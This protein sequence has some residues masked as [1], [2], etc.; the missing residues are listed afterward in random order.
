MALVSTSL[1]VL[2]CRSGDWRVT[3]IHG[4][5]HPG[6][7]SFGSAGCSGYMDRDSLFIGRLLDRTLTVLQKKKNLTTVPNMCGDRCGNRRNPVRHE[8]CLRILFDEETM[9]AP[10]IPADLCNVFDFEAVARECLPEDTW[11]YLAEGSDDG[12]TLKANRSAFASIQIRARRLVDVS[13]IDTT[14][15]LPGESLDSPILIAP[16][17]LQR[18]FHADAEIATVRATVAAG[19]RF[20][21]S[22]VSSCSIAKIA[23]AA[24]L[25]PWF[26]IYAM[27]DHGVTREIVRRA[28]AAGC[29]VMI[30]TVDVPVLGNRE[31][32]LSDLERRLQEG[33]V[34]LGN[35]EGLPRPHQIGDPSLTWSFIAEL[36]EM[37]GAK[38]FVKGIVTRGDAKLC[39][40]H[41]VDGVIVSNHG[42]RQEDSLRGSIE[43]L[44]EVVDVIAGR[45]P[46]LLDSGIRRGTDIF[47]GLALGAAAVCVGRPII[48]GLASFG[49]A[50]VEAVLQRLQQELVRVMQLAG[51]PTIARIDRTAVMLP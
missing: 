4:P 13:R 16:I 19:H 25:P 17:G 2:Y 5:C 40:A 50:G 6:V 12:G 41:G 49:Q 18:T 46:V 29:P 38:L 15:E 11:K 43:C 32:H 36:R 23:A 30:L 14:I 37:T 21:A 48:W 27:P 22:T 51:T 3:D 24:R 42:G 10:V 28:D 47:K 9:N 34:P 7:K 45:V 44:P 26:Q 35:F 1:R 33:T 39:L 8:C 20:I 31:G